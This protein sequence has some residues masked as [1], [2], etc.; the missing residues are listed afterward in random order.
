M[1]ETKAIE[2]FVSGK[3]GI[4]A[5]PPWA[6]DWPLPD[7]FQN[8]P[9]AVV[10]AYPMPSGPDGNI[11][12][13]G[14]GYMTGAFLF[15]KDFKH[16]DAFLK[17]YDAIYGYVLG[18][19]EYFEDGI[20]EGYDYVM[21][22][23]APVYDQDEIPDG[24]INPGKYFLLGDIPDVPF[25]QYELLKEFHRGE[26]EAK[27]AYENILVAR[28]PLWLES[29]AIITD[30][31]EFRIEN[32]FTGPP[33][34]TSRSKGEFLGK[35]QSQTF[36]E[37]IYGKAPLSDFDKFVEEWKVGGGDEITKEVNEWYESVGTE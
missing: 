36:S 24:W 20:F 35:M 12:R 28:G 19:S 33:T 15:N 4:I 31:N 1:D 9:E 7:L 32:L 3:S 10:K 17:Y 34:K 27:T 6:A 22:D 21:K 14:E 18:E 23:G 26:R 29:G 30:Q 11:G 2:S 16:V 5:A 37:I 25:Q 8:D 13:K